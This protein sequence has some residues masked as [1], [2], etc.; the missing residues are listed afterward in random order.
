MFYI[1]NNY[2]SNLQH[3]PLLQYI[4]AS[5]MDII[6]NSYFEISAVPQNQT[7]EL[8][9]HFIEKYKLPRDDVKQILKLFNTYKLVD[10]LNV[11]KVLYAVI[12]NNS[13]LFSPPSPTNSVTSDSEPEIFKHKTSTLV[14]EDDSS[15]ETS[16]SYMKRKKLYIFGNK[17]N[18]KILQNNDFSLINNLPLGKLGTMANEYEISS[19][20][21][22]K[23]HNLP[24]LRKSS[25]GEIIIAEKIRR[26]YNYKININ[27]DEV[28]NKLTISSEEDK[29]L[30][31]IKLPIILRVDS[32]EYED[33]YYVSSKLKL[34]QEKI[35]YL[36]MNYNVTAS[37]EVPI[38]NIKFNDKLSRCRKVR[39]F[40]FWQLE[41]TILGKTYTFK[42]SFRKNVETDSSE[43][44]IECEDFIPFELFASTYIAI[45]LYYKYQ[46]VT[47]EEDCIEPVLTADKLMNFKQSEY[48]E[49]LTDLQKNALLDLKLV[50]YK[51][52]AAN[53]VP[54][55]L[56]EFILLSTLR[57]YN[58]SFKLEFPDVEPFTI[59][60][61]DMLQFK[62]LQFK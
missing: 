33:G 3:K 60:D 39:H 62:T 41:T 50:P 12:Y 9:Q 22:L 18:S 29:N 16:D 46:H 8:T 56:Y 35:V 42:V 34:K 61:S 4:V 45:V 36:N 58:E 23:N 38:N 2:K 59:I 43:C 15:D 44:N 10:V 53:D 52:D 25:S 24:S 27:V 1:A 51:E 30:K 57:L 20:F 40:V 55:H 7:V 49:H 37:V 5:A 17:N 48:F 14:E 6:K 26:Y 11:E 21:M 54:Q 13:M 47:Y 19:N 31:S 32:A 28:T